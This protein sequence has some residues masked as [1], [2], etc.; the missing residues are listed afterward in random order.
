MPVGKWER[1]ERRRT[2]EVGMLGGSWL[3]DCGV[4]SV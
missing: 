4:I 3:V 2:E 1:E